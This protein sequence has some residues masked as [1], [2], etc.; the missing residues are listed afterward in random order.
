MMDVRNGPAVD[1]T[2]ATASGASFSLRHFSTK[3][4]GGHNPQVAYL[5]ALGMKLYGQQPPFAG[6]LSILVR[7]AERTNPNESAVI[8]I[9][10]IAVWNACLFTGAAVRCWGCPTKLRAAH[11]LWRSLFRGQ[12]DRC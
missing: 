10:V 6:R 4:N 11:P 7:D 3:K 1:G 8:T 12:T 9:H 2:Q 5:G